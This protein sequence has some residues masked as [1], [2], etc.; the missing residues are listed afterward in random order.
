MDEEISKAFDNLNTKFDS[1]DIEVQ[2]THSS[3]KSLQGDV[4]EIKNQ[5]LQNCAKLD[6][7][8]QHLGIQN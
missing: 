2:N 3:L 4:S 7:V 1:L 5:I 6:K 8:I